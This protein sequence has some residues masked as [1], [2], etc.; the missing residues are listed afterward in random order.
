M[1]SR[2]SYESKREVGF[3][4]ACLIPLSSHPAHVQSLAARFYVNRSD[5]QLLRQP[6]SS[7]QGWRMEYQVRG[8]LK[9]CM[10]VT[11]IVNE[12]L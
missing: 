6:V 2:N 3:M 11:Y 7:G 8:L 1:M 10:A 12:G 5:T 9:Q 4:H